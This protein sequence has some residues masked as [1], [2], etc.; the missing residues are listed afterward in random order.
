MSEINLL[1]EYCKLCTSRG[2]CIECPIK[3]VKEGDCRQWI[4]E[5]WDQAV[6]II[7]K[8]AKEHPQKTRQDV[9]L[10]RYPDAVVDNTKVL[11]IKPCYMGAHRKENVMCGGYNDCYDCRKDYWSAP[12]EEE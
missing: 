10:E 11:G 6:E 2:L 4:L 7:T 12:A 3:E 1:R 8:W 5:H 9:F